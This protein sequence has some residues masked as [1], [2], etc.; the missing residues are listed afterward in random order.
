MRKRGHA[1][2]TRCG[3]AMRDHVKPGCGPFREGTC[4][5]MGCRCVLTTEEI[6][7]APRAKSADHDG[8]PWAVR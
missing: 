4:P 6:A 3:H 8:T 5:W 1:N 2:C 7:K